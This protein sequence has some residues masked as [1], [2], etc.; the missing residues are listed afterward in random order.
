M[1][2]C[3]APSPPKPAHVLEASIAHTYSTVVYFNLQRLETNFLFLCLYFL[4][5]LVK[6]KPR[7]TWGDLSSFCW[8][9]CSVCAV[10]GLVASSCSLFIPSLKV[11]TLLSSHAAPT[12]SSVP[13]I[14]G[15]FHLLRQNHGSQS[16]VVVTSLRFFCGS[17]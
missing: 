7:V 10:P 8:W 5:S 3:Y 1:S 13:W 16:S 9:L 2:R 14:R 6:G 11:V 12:L 15:D 4:A 17:F